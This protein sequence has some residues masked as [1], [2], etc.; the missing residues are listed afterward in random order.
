MGDCFLSHRDTY[1]RDM[2]MHNN[3]GDH[4]DCGET[5]QATWKFIKDKK[6]NYYIKLQSDQ[7]PKLMNIEKDHKYFKLLQLTEE[8]MTLQFT[9]KQFSSKTTTIT[10]IYVPE[11]M[12]IQ[13]R[14]FHW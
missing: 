14:E 9:H 10:D 8:Q 13:D 5:L 6:G 1:K 4:R 12:V 11:N 2:S 7:I 3:S